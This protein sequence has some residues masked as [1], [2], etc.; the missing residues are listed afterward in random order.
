MKKLLAIL[1]T[2]M[3]CLGC[4]V[5]AIAEETAVEE[6]AGATVINYDLDL[7]Y[8]HITEAY[9]GVMA[10]GEYVGFASDEDGSFAVMFFFNQEEHITFVGPASV[11]G[12]AVSIADE[13][14][15]LEITFTV[16]VAEEGHVAIDIGEYG[17]GVIEAMDTAD[18]VDALESV[19][20]N[21]FTNEVEAE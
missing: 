17:A 20:T 21:T 5:W 16:E 13:V 4:S 7:I 8:E 1:L 2:L 11:D 14:N 15:G 3:V 19:L 9:G 12:N 6:D 18:F 10:N